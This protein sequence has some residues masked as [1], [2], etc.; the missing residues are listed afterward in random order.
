MLWLGYEWDIYYIT[1][2]L[3]LFIINSIDY[4]GGSKNATDF[5]KKVCCWSY[6]SSY[7]WTIMPI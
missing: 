1:Y 6:W 2:I 5:A 3:S 7:W 4:N